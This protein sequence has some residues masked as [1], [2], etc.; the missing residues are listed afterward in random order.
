MFREKVVAITGGAG[1][2]GRALGQRFGGD[3]AHIV[4]LDRD[5]EA[6]AGAAEML[7]AR[8][9]AVLSITC[10]VTEEAAA[11]KAMA[12]IRERFGRLDV[13][14]HCAGLTHVSPFRET[15]LEVY[16]RVMEVN[17][18]ATVACTKAALPML[19]ENQGQ[20]VVLS[21][22]AGFAPLLAR[23]GYCASKYALHGFF[24]TL[25]AELKED[26][27]GVL[28]VC[29]SFVATDFAKS[30][31]AGDGTTLSFERSTTG[32]PLT[33][34]EVASAIH[35]AARKHKPLLVIP[36]KAKLAYWVSRILPGVYERVMIRR[37]HIEL[38][39]NQ[40]EGSPTLDVR[41]HPLQKAR[42]TK[43]KKEEA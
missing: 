13:L 7:E 36:S 20:I 21:S 38:D 8:G 3:G 24:E 40:G 25:R 1:G 10:D 27:V 17:F 41:S 42:K 12:A 5:P 29:P 18:F 19:I 4:L 35:R 32:K 37:F 30:G 43:K 28:L 22:I 16:R 2:M 39:R 26:G 34:H 6:L 33:P 14:I 9:I 11:P 15:D 31:L 23:T